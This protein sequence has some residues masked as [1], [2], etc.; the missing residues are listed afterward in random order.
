MNLKS[1]SNWIRGPIKIKFISKREDI[2]MKVVRMDIPR[3]YFAGFLLHSKQIK[4][5]ESSELFI[6]RPRLETLCTFG[7][8]K[9]LRSLI[10]AFRTLRVD[11]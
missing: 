2:E 3:R 7:S 10:G 5:D 9:M 8:L 11:V 1:T 6:A 4:R